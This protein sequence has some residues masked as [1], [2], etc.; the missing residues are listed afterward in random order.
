MTLGDAERLLTAQLEIN[1][2]LRSVLVL[3]ASRAPYSGPNNTGTE[4]Y[5]LSSTGRD[6]FA[7]LGWTNPV[8]TK[9]MK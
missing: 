4:R 2:R 8:K 6:A 9:E 5:A 3:M 7:L 1:A